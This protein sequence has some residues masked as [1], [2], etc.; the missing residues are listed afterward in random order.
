MTLTPEQVQRV[1]ALC[2]AFDN[3]TPQTA[4]V[5]AWTQVFAQDGELTLHDALAAVTQHYAT[6][7]IWIMPAHIR[8]IAEQIRRARR[9]TLP[10]VEELMAGVDP[11]DPR[12]SE[13]RREREQQYLTGQ[14]A[15]TTQG[16][17][18]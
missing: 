4:V 18:P 17:T 9:A 13:I 15:I 1:L 2:A 6:E 12:W 11:D 16:A 8:R 5:A 14:R 3:R 7:T 10:P